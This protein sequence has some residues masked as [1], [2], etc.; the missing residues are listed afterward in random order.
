MVPGSE[1]PEN[2][3]DDRNTCEPEHGQRL[4]K[5]VMSGP[6]VEEQRMDRIA[7]DQL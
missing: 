7:V 5:L 3:K 4:D 2:A 6:C 1:S